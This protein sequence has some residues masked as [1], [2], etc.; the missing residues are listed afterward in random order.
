MIG[1]RFE[2]K[3]HDP[4]GDNVTPDLSRFDDLYCDLAPEPELN[5]F[6]QLAK[7]IAAHAERWCI[8]DQ[9]FI[10]ARL[11]LVAGYHM[12]RDHRELW[13][14]IERSHRELLSDLEHGN[15]TGVTH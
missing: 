11:C 8:E 3:P 10:L 14:L 4:R 2:G 12:G 7:L 9:A 1:C 5:E 6:G 15:E 13:P